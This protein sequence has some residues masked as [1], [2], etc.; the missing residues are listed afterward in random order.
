MKTFKDIE[1]IHQHLDD[2][3]RGTLYRVPCAVS[4]LARDPEL[5]ICVFV[6]QRRTS[7]G[8]LPVDDG[9]PNSRRPTSVGGQYFRFFS[10]IAVGVRQSS[11]KQVGIKCISSEGECTKE[12]INIDSLDAG[13]V[14]PRGLRGCLIRSPSLMTCES[15][16][17]LFEVS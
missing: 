13:E 3:L 6:L 5:S 10:Y 11:L 4:S 16:S 14:T 17:N 9:G 15:D 1:R 8:G 7:L 2:T 12:S